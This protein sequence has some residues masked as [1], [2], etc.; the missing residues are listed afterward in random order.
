MFRLPDDLI[1]YFCLRRTFIAMK[2][3]FSILDFCVVLQKV[4][5]EGDNSPPTSYAMIRAA[6][7]LYPRLELEKEDD[8]LKIPFT[9]CIYQNVQI[10]LKSSFK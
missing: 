1:V 5:M 8:T 2:I 10:L 9:E 3:N 6:E 7:E 4:I